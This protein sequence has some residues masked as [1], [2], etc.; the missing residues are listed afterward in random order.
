ME[1][2]HSIFSDATAQ[3]EALFPVGQNLTITYYTN[4]IDALAE[5]NPIVDISNHR[6]ETSANTQ[7]IYVRVDSDDINACLGLG[8]HI[9]LVVDPIPIN[10]PITNYELCSDNN[11]AVFD[12]TTKDIEVLGGQAVPILISYHLNEQ[13]AIN[14]IPIANAGNYTNLANPQTIYVRAQFDDN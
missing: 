12:L 2:P 4:E 11:Q 9:T 5:T 14:N 3:V 13:D 10:N 6:N 8:S 7:Q 1:Q